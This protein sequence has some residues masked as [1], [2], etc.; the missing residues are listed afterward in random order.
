MKT[1]WWHKITI[2]NSETH[3]EIFQYD[4]ED[5]YSSY[6][7]LPIHLVN[8]TI[9]IPFK[10]IKTRITRSESGVINK[11]EVTLYFRSVKDNW[12]V[13][14]ENNNERIIVTKGEFEFG[15]IK[16]EIDTKS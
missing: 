3:A 7:C 11:S 5:Y 13:V 10:T 14:L 12:E 9:E 16:I 15:N 4:L 6:N 2:K 8:G 1:L